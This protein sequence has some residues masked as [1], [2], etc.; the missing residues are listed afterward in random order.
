MCPPSNYAMSLL[1]AYYLHRMSVTISISHGNNDTC[2]LERC[3]FFFFIP[4]FPLFFTYF[5]SVLSFLSVSPLLFDCC[6][7]LF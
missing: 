6:L 7:Y 1:H 5:N 2:H 4:P 3:T